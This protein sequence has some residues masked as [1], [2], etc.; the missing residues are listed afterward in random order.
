MNKEWFIEAHEVLDSYVAL[1]NIADC[2]DDSIN[3]A[4]KQ[5]IN[6]YH[7]SVELT[8]AFEDACTL[9][10]YIKQTGIFSEKQV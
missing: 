4:S 2:L 5:V 1:E 6:P 7:S 10:D 3:L 8:L 9:Y